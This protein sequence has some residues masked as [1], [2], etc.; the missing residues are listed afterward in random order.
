MI[1]KTPVIQINNPNI[2]VKFIFSFKNKIER[3]IIITGDDV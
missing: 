3:K 2:L 1:M